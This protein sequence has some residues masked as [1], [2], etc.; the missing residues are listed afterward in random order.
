MPDFIHDT[1]L[2]GWMIAGT[3]MCIG[4]PFLKCWVIVFLQ[5]DRWMRGACGSSL[6]ARVPVVN[7]LT[8]GKVFPNPNPNQNSNSFS[9]GKHFILIRV[10]SNATPLERWAWSRN[11]PWM[12]APVNCGAACNIKDRF[13]PLEMR[14]MTTLKHFIPLC[15]EM[16]ELQHYCSSAGSGSCWNPSLVGV[17]TA[18]SE[19][20]HWIKHFIYWTRPTSMAVVI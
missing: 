2:A 16:V 8:A 12:G 14:C 20:P 1:W 11:T 4:V 7:R 15:V 18:R 5:M 13:R 9:F 6:C 17:L 10:M 19:N 3:Y